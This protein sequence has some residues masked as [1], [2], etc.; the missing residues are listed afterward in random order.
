MIEEFEQT[1]RMIEQVGFARIHVFPYSPRPGTPAAEYPGQ[2]PAAVKEQRARE[3]ISLGSR[4]SDAYL[5]SWNGL[6]TSLIPEE[7]VDGC[8]E[9]YTPEYIRVRLDSTEQCRPGQPV[10]VRLV[11]AG[12]RLM[13]GEIIDE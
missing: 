13:D 5:D 9:G 8:W 2:L 4:V 11:K 1:K 10:E 7:K 12:P 6:E 3:L